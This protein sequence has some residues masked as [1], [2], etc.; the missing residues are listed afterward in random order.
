MNAATKSSD[1]DC[2]ADKGTDALTM[3]RLNGRHVADEGASASVQRP[4]GG[5]AADARMETVEAVR[6]HPLYQEHLARLAELERD[7]VFCRHGIGHLLDTARIAWIFNLEYN[8]GF[9]KEAVY[10]AALM[11]DIGKDE[12][13]ERGIPHEEA[14]ARIAREILDDMGA[15][16]DESEC[17]AIVAAIREHRRLPEGASLLGTMLYD[18]DK[19]SRTCFACPAREDCSWSS[20]KM[21]LSVRV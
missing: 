20:E 9:R 21:N 17:D 1:G 6:S 3:R 4:S 8:L 11:H 19:A 7:R 15:A 13:Y 18:A 2:A 12:Q 16:F 14:S 10:A 5:F